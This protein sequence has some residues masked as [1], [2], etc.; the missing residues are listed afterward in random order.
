MR[1]FYRTSTNPPSVNQLQDVINY[2]NPLQ[3]STGNPNLEQQ[4][5]HRFGLRYQFANTQKGQSLFVNFFGTQTN[6]YV[7]NA[8]Y[9]AFSDSV[10][11]PTVTLYRGSQLSK[12]VNLDGQYNLNTFVTFGMPVKFIK[13]NL[14]LNA[15][16]GYSKTHHQGLHQRKITGL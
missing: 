2:S 12:P 14:N 16:I 11:T 8:T 4:Y 10:L 1:L 6:N 15:G 13:S 9:R 7:A 3:V 5:S